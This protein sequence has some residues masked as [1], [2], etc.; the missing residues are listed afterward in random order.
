MKIKTFTSKQIFDVK[1]YGMSELF[2]K[3]YLF[4]K[5]LFRIPVNI[6]AILPCLIIRLISPWIIIRIEKFPCGNFGKKAEI[7][8]L[9][10]C[11]KK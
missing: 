7:P 1:T 3:F 4:I 9:Y 11:K 6:I 5:V 2:R 10:Q 8:A